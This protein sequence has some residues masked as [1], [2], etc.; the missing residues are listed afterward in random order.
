MAEEGH[1]SRS[2]SYQCKI[3]I[4][5]IME[6]HGEKYA[7]MKIVYALREWASRLVG[8]ILGDER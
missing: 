4:S 3:D 2:A 7:D 6:P 5:V 1:L 8:A